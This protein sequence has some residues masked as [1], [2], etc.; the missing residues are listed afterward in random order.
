MKKQILLLGIL[1]LLAMSCENVNDFGAKTS[2]PD[3]D[4]T[5]VGALEPIAFGLIPGTSLSEKS[6]SDFDAMTLSDFLNI[7]K[8]NIYT[9]ND[10]YICFS[11][12]GTLYYLPLSVYDDVNY[13]IFREIV[14]RP[15]RFI[16]FYESYA[17]AQYQPLIDGKD[18]E[19]LE[20][21]NF[22]FDEATQTIC[23]E[24]IDGWSVKE[25][26]FRLRYASADVI[27]LESE[28]SEKE[29]LQWKLSDDKH[30]FVREVMLLHKDEMA[31][32]DTVI[33][34]RK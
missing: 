11:E 1:T 16:K 30:Y 18:G 19:I 32:P 20:Y 28:I 3:N 2:N 9:Q 10:E 15:A 8:D 34:H 5:Q 6:I 13:N 14:G 33:D 7:T 4:S 17:T 25:N 21:N 23:S 31:T 24:S 26:K 22:N 27:V 12:D 29:K